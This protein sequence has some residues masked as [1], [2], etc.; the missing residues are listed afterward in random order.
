MNRFRRDE[1][2]ESAESYLR[3]AGSDVEV[4][5]LVREKLYASVIGDVL[6]ALGRNHQVLR[7][8]I[9]PLAPGMKLVGRAMPALNADV[10]G[11]QREPFGRLAESLDQLEPNEV[12]VSCGGTMRCAYWGEILT[13]AARTR[14]AAG[15]V[16]DGFHRD[17]ARVLEQS[18]PVFS[19]GGHAQDSAVRLKVIDYR[20]PI[21]IGGVWIEPGD[22]IVGDVDGVVVVPGDVE[23]EVIERGLEK[24]SAENAVRKAIEGG[25]ST[26]K[27]FDTYGV[28]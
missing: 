10:F 13:V 11:P 23:S 14:G 16:V 7:P 22:L 28:L 5:S 20:V 15:A 1:R 27:A 25:M 6:D 17:T 2:T 3:S 19:R 4:L 18:W 12:Y 8:E 9:R 24:A 26:V 21:E